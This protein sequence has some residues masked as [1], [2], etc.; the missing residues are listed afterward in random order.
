MLFVEKK[1]KNVYK[2]VE[3][4]KKVNK[5]VWKTIFLEIKLPKIIAGQSDRRKLQPLVISV[6]SYI[7][8]RN[9]W[10]VFVLLFAWK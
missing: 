10:I 9:R 2:E 3:K 4:K 7:C 8:E 1:K 6:K 5:E